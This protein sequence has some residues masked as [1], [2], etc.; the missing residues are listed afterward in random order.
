MSTAR[1]CRFLT[2]TVLFQ[3]LL[4]DLQ[5]HL[6]VRHRRALQCM[7]TMYTVPD[8]HHIKRLCPVND[9]PTFISVHI[10]AVSANLRSQN[11]FEWPEIKKSN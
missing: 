1:V 4:Q 11:I 2:S 5:S 7:F 10:G 3:V 8:C 9:N 6:H